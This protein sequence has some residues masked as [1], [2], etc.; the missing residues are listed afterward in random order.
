MLGLFL[1][2]TM[3]RLKFAT[4]LLERSGF[5]RR[6]RLYDLKSQRG[7]CCRYPAKKDCVEL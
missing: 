3:C 6:S 2:V 7:D 1:K 5:S 4:R